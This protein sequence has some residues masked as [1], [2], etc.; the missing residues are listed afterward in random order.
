M[1]GALP[2]DGKEPDKSLRVRTGRPITVGNSVEISAR[3]RG[4]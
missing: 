1:H 2:R 4:R 3:D